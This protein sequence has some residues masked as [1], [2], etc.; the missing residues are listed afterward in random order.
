M[1]LCCATQQKPRPSPPRKGRGF[2]CHHSQARSLRQRTFAPLSSPLH[3][4]SQALYNRP[5]DPFPCANLSTNSRSGKGVLVGAAHPCSFLQKRLY[6]PRTLRSACLGRLPNPIDDSPV[7]LLAQYIA[8][9][10]TCPL[11][12]HCSIHSAYEAVHRLGFSLSLRSAFWGSPTP[13]SSRVR[14][15]GSFE[16]SL[17]SFTSPRKQLRTR[18]LRVKPSP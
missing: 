11:P 2:I 18:V 4:D 10:S 15:S 14:V 9:N 8:E 13:F 3:F 7:T 17:H 6:R 1:H 16:K 5:A 12:H